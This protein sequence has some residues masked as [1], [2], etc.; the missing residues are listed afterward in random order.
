MAR[1]Y[2]DKFRSR[3]RRTLEAGR[4]PSM[5]SLVRDLGVI[6]A[7]PAGL[8]CAIAARHAGFE[9][10]VF[11]QADDIRSGGVGITI[12]T[13]GLRALDRLSLLDDFFKVAQRLTRARVET[14]DGTTLLTL[15][16]EESGGPLSCFAGVARTDLYRLLYQAATASGVRFSMPKRCVFAGPGG[17]VRFEDGETRRFDVVVGADGVNS[18]VRETLGLRSTRRPA[19]GAVLQWI[20]QMTLPDSITREI[21]AADGSAALLVPISGGRTH[22]AFTAPPRWEA[23]V[24]TGVDEWLA[25]WRDYPDEVLSALSSVRDWA[26]VRHDEV[27][28]VVARPWHR[29]STVI[30]GDAA[31]AMAPWAGQG[32]STAMVDALMLIDQLARASSV[33]DALST[34]EK[35]R[36][37][38]V[39]RFQRFARTGASVRRWSSRYKRFVRDRTI[40]LLDRSAW[41]RRRQVSFLSGS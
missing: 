24:S 15:D 11:E 30:I 33:D 10:S 35:G 38:E 17:E 25:S 1:R 26:G 29:G 39:T 28:E 3:G 5:P 36:R 7:G 16:Y 20:A 13:N 6:G 23:V 31:H 18:C 19:G 27:V 4:F 14:A 32:A 40:R 21:W 41:A 34:Y 2:A 22:C 9:V 37:R 12:A 8:A